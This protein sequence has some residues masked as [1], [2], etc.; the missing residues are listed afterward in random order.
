MKVMAMDDKVTALKKLL[1]SINGINSY[2]GWHFA[3]LHEH[4]RNRTEPISLWQ[5][6]TRN[7]EVGSQSHP[8]GT[9]YKVANLS[10]LRNPIAST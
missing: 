2:Q 1:S 4:Y 5:L 8:E 7:A 6:Y 3:I 10:T 9:S